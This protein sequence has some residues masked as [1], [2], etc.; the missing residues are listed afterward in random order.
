MKLQNSALS[1][2][3]AGHLLHFQQLAILYL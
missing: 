1:T 3:S 2:P